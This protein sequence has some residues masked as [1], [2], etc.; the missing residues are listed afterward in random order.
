MDGIV[1]IVSLTRVLV[2]CVIGVRFGCIGL[3][4]TTVRESGKSNSKENKQA[5]YAGSRLFSKAFS[6]RRVVGELFISRA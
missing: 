6:V 1:A 3:V 4:P 2:S 5:Y